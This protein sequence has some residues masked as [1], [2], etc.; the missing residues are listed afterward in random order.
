[1]IRAAWTAM[2]GTKAD[3]AEAMAVASRRGIIRHRGRRTDR[4]ATT[5]AMPSANQRWLEPE[6]RRARLV[7]R[8]PNQPRRVISGKPLPHSDRTAFRP[9]R[10]AS[11]AAKPHAGDDSLSLP[12][13]LQ[14]K[15]PPFPG[16]TGGGRESSPE[17]GATPEGDS[18]PGTAMAPSPAHRGREK[19][20]AK[21][22]RC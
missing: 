19:V 3:V 1:M 10:V 5:L 13:G 6:R 7:L 4:T 17:S 9:G 14:L 20:V 18:L 15:P 2:T 8:I 16:N 12:R 11:A 21:P 22:L